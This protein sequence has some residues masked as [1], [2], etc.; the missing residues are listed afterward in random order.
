MRSQYVL[1]KT[2][3]GNSLKPSRRL[4]AICM[5][6]WKPRGGNKLTMRMFVMTPALCSSL[7]MPGWLW[8][9]RFAL[10]MAAEIMIRAAWMKRMVLSQRR[11]LV[12]PL[13][14]T[15]A[16]LRKVRKAPAR[17]EARDTRV[18]VQA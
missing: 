9:T 15:R 18:V 12:T 1:V 8:G 11:L 16:V 2:L 3:T 7:G 4:V 5:P 10:T 14:L 17:K 6:D 13:G